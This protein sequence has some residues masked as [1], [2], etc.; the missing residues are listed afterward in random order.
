MLFFSSTENVTSETLDQLL[1]FT[2]E[3]LLFRLRTF[4]LFIF[5]ANR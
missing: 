5:L 1:S 3:E 4:L 2:F